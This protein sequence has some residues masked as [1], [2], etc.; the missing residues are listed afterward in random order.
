MRQRT[1]GAPI[2]HVVAPEPK[3]TSVQQKSVDHDEDLAETDKLCDL[4]SSGFTTMFVW[5]LGSVSADPPTG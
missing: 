3:V 2:G 5:L 4:I 1:D